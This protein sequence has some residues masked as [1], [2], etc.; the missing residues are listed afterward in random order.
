MILV[1]GASG[2]LGQHLLAQLSKQGLTVR[3]LSRHKKEATDSIE[4][5]Q[6]DILD[7]DAL[8]KAFHGVTQVYH[9]AG[10]VSFHPKQRAI[11]MKINQ[12]GTANVVNLAL[13]CKVQK[14]IHVSSIAALGRAE[15]G[16]QIDETTEW[17]K[18]KYNSNYAISKYLAEIEVWRAYAEGLNVAVVNP[19]VILGEGDWTMGTPRLFALVQKG[20]KFYTTGTNGFVDVQ[21]VVAAMIQLMRSD[22]SGERYILSGEDLRY[23]E[24]FHLMAKALNK[25]AP[26]I[27]VTK[28]LGA[29]AWRL[30]YLKTFFYGQEP[31]ITRETVRTGN[32][33]FLYAHHKVKKDLLLQFTP[34]ATTIQ[35]TA[36]ALLNTQEKAYY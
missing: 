27:R 8:E 25:K 11:M 16:Q 12:E 29:F 31:M 3:A 30:A 2:F 21:D 28:L 23:R 32:H 34:I 13:K 5:F 4:W 20:L 26:S 15:E 9:C 35:R 17:Q 7:V 36:A 10:H 33:H 14:L 1:T 18:S 6:A 19:A 24:L 22:I